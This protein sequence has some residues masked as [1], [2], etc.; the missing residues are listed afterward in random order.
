MSSTNPIYSDFDRVMFNPL[1]NQKKSSFVATGLL[2]GV[3]CLHLTIAWYFL[4]TSTVTPKPE[5]TVI[6]EVVMQKSAPAIKPAAPAPEPPKPV[7]K[8]E[9][10]KPKPVIKP[11]PIVKPV[12]VKKPEPMVE[13]VLPMPA[14]SPAP[15]APAVTSATTSTTNAPKAIGPSNNT[16]TVSSGVVALFRVPPEYPA[17]AA[18]RHIE[19]W[20]KVEFTVQTDGSV[21]DAVVISAEPE[22]IFDEAALA[23]ISKWRFKE[24]IVNGVA[25]AQRAVQKLQFKLE[26]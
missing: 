10:E 1:A 7:V 22:E 25:V 18:N 13:E 2:M 3:V 23:A 8:K 12:A 19:G 20:V 14:F 24:K 6:M 9:P 16:P 4:N 17:R 15:P 21:D 5:E 26:H 11:K